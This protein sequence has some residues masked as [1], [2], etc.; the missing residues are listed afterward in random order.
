MQSLTPAQCEHIAARSGNLPAAG[1]QA[2][3]PGSSGLKRR[4]GLFDERLH[5][6]FFR[7]RLI[8]MALRPF[9]KMPAALVMAMDDA[10]HNSDWHEDFSWQ[11]D[12]ASGAAGA[13][14]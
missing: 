14:G 9:S 12:A 5:N 1:L 8:R 7:L 4:V 10:G 6:V 13:R 3:P 2:V 11:P